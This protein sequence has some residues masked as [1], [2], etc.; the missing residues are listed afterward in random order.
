M[1]APETKTKHSDGNLY[2]NPAPNAYGQNGN[3]ASRGCTGACTAVCA[4]YC[5][6]ACE[7][8]ATGIGS[9]PG[10]GSVTKKVNP[11]TTT[12]Y[13]KYSDIYEVYPYTKTSHKD[14]WEKDRDKGILY[15]RYD[16]LQE[17]LD[18]YN[19]NL[20]TYYNDANNFKVTDKEKEK[21]TQ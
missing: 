21:I 13:V 2:L 14:Q 20:K 5:G 6:I 11:D 1:P 18:D 8:G 15:T 7:G 17:I 19:N 3:P 10:T 16:T 9:Y 4:N 12:Y